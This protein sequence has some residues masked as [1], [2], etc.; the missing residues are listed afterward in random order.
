MSLL[1]IHKLSAHYGDFQALY[2]IDFF[3]EQG[4]TVAI[5]GANGAGKSTFLKSISGV[6]PVKKDAITFDGETIGGTPSNEV[7]SKGIA[8][9]PEGRRLFT[10]LTVEEN[11]QMGAYSQKRA[12]EWRLETV[13]ELFP[14]LQER[15]TQA[16]GSLSGGEQQ[17][18]AIGRALMSNPKLL[19]FDEL[20]LGLAPVII[21]HIYET[22]AK[23]RERKTTMLLVE[24]DIRQAMNVADRVYCFQ[25]G[26][27][28]LH[29]RPQELTQEEISRAYF[30]V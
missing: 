20:S 6:V 24:Q 8:L 5:I 19:M 9:V 4:E 7:V 18:V 11:L 30:G 2:D 26:R 17:M 28:S 23:I 13:Y 14:R 16:A 27:V 22:L 1:E 15:R 12:G 29:G 10:S 25:E 3:A 21:L